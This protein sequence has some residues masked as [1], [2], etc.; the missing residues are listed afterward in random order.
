MG[1]CSILDYSTKCTECVVRCP[2]AGHLSCFVGV[3]DIWGHT[4]QVVRATQTPGSLE[5]PQKHPNTNEA[6]HNPRLLMGPDTGTCSHSRTFLSIWYSHAQCGRPAEKLVRPLASFA[7]IYSIH[8]ITNVSPQ[9]FY[10]KSRAPFPLRNS[11]FSKILPL[12][13]NQISDSP[14]GSCDQCL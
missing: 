14:G 3:Y 13:H 6:F 11:F 2:A 4:L 9:S 8:C 5:Q 7:L 12:S 10:I 1:W